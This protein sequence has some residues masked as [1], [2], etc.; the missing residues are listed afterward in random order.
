[1]NINRPIDGWKIKRDS[2]AKLVVWFKDGNTRTFYSLDWKFPFSKH[3][4]QI[5][6]IKRLEEKLKNWDA[7]CGY[8]ILYDN[9]TG[10]E[11]K[12]YYQGKEIID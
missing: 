9:Q 1:M 7:K 6:G 12:R 4:D 3:A 2:F 8:A 11:I 10:A 5:I